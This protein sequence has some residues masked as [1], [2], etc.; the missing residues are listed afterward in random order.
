MHR[1]YTSL[2]KH[3]MLFFFVACVPLLSFSE[4]LNNGYF[5]INYDGYGI[6]SLKVD[7]NGTGQYGAECLTTGK[8]LQYIS[9]LR[10]EGN[11]LWIEPLYADI[12]WPLPFVREGY[13][14]SDRFIN[15]PHENNVLDAT[16]LVLPVHELIGSSGQVA[17]IEHF[18]RLPLGLYYLWIN[19][20]QGDELLMRSNPNENW[21]LL[22]TLP[23]V[24]RINY[25]IEENAILFNG[26]GI[27]DTMCIE[28][29]QRASMQTPHDSLA[30]PLVKFTPDFTLSFE[31]TEKL[32]SA[33]QI[34]TEFMQHGIYW[35][36]T[37]TTTS[38][39]ILGA[40]ETHLLDDPRSFYLKQI[41]QD[42]LNT[43]GNIGYDRF[44][45]MGYMYAWGRYPDYGAGGLL[46]VAGPP[47]DSSWDVRFLHLNGLWIHSVVQYILA[48]GDLDLLQTRRARKISTNGSE[49]QPICGK[50]AN[51][52]DSVLV[53]GDR[54]LDE[55]LPTKHHSLGQSFKAN[56][57]FSAVSAYV[58]NTTLDEAANGQLAL[59]DH[60]DGNQIAQLNFTVPA[61]VSKEV[62]LLIGQTLPAG[63]YYLELTNDASGQ[64]YFAPNLVWWTDIDSGY[65]QGDAYTGPLHGDLNDMLGYLFEYMRNYMGAA[66]KNLTYHAN[67]PEYN[68][69]SHHSGRQWQCTMT[70]YW[71][72]AGGGYDA[73]E[74]IW[75][76]AA[77]EAM[78]QLNELNGQN[79]QVYRNLRNLAD[80]A[81][82]SKYWH[83]INE[84]GETFS[85]YLGCED[86]DGVIRDFG[87]TYNNLE[88]AVRDI[89]AMNQVHDILWWLDRGQWKTSTTQWSN[90]IYSIWEVAP[91]YNTIE[92]NTWLNVTGTL[93][94][95]EVV[96]NGGTRLTIAARDL[97]TRSRYLSIDNM[98]ER[99]M[100]LLS[101]YAS[102]D[103]LT[104]GR[105][106][107]DPGGRG[108]WQ[109]L[110]PEIDRQDI[111]GFREIFP[112]DGVVA[113]IQPQAY[114]N[115][116][117]S[118]GGMMIR[119]E[120]PADLESI[121]FENIGYWGGLFN[122]YASAD[123]TEVANLSGGNEAI[124]M[125]SDIIV[126]QTFIVNQTFN[127][128]GVKV[129]IADQKDSTNHHVSLTLEIYEN[130]QWEVLCKNWY[131]HLK[132]G[133]WIWI[134]FETPIPAESSC[135]ILVH[136]AQSSD[137]A[138]IGLAFSSSDVWPG[139]RAFV[140]SNESNAVI[141]DLNLRIISEKINFVAECIN[142]PQLHP[143]ELT[144]SVENLRREYLGR[145]IYRLSARM[146]A[147]ETVILSPYGEIIQTSAASWVLY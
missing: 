58:G 140:V 32:I 14:D 3:G 5:V 130:D 93:P 52:M 34:A 84:N 115:M 118:A 95:R 48:T 137:D 63:Q 123:R 128:V 33:S 138:S 103:R 47:E 71:E 57:P 110:G 145:G 82:N 109:F 108:R 72:G 105:T 44:E 104:G 94:Y 16:T 39:W 62:A 9:N 41:R 22:L 50:N 65:T 83:S 147:G 144:G 36:P 111:E 132:D 27:T 23:G 1:I 21:D 8:K 90:D 54:R 18:K 98:H 99:N 75:Y 11:K 51:V 66:E 114:L 131:N 146:N 59:Y 43:F 13:Y 38:D 117:Y 92:N 25:T 12:T 60:Y 68:C 69:G 139:G 19:L 4:T 55:T 81:Y 26:N 88:A 121:T 79:S 101:R 96:T 35:Y 29:I 20:A 100:R 10:L 30:L 28:V 17:R 125:D 112:Q 61:N 46:N 120:I 85:R 133:Q 24:Q 49:T 102:P 113:S 40:V 80:D 42:I 78:A 135:R 76:N 45:H 73:F 7:A 142:N 129:D 134:A 119:P 2:M 31:P 87:F 70:S 56:A 107:E 37:V 6:T 106:Y 64:R 124:T 116:S 15:Y 67:D 97:L 89:P 143:F 136:D 141:G 74:S 122:F 77:C 86:W 126:G 53:A 91:P 127:K